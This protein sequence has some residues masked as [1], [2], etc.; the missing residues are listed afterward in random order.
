MSERDTVVVPEDLAGVRVDRAL[1]V[2]TNMG[3]TASRRL[4]EDG[5]VLIDGVAVDRSTAL[6]VGDVI[7]YPVIEQA[8]A[9]IA[10]EIPFSVVFESDDVVVVDKPPGLVVHP[11]AGHATGTLVNGLIHRYPDLQELGEEYRWGLVH[12]LDRDTSGLLLVARNPEMHGFLQRE[13]KE[14][15]IGRTYVALVSGGLEAATGT[16]DAPIGRDPA[17]PTRMAIVQDGRPARTHYR[18]LAE[19]AE[20]TLVQ[21][22]LETGRTHQIRVHFASVGRGIVGDPVYGRGIVEEGDPGRVWLH[23]IRLRFPVGSGTA[24]G[25]YV[26][27]LEAPLP[28]DLRRSLAALGDPA[29]GQVDL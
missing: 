1:A 25:A 22:E 13:L 9:L 28:A 11:G 19:W 23:A 10:E 18:R 20:V 2:L 6:S 4:I 26:Q 3:R 27:E 14:R 7:E 5:L 24:L 16:I 29:S 15:R 17:R 8:P 21:I 12:R